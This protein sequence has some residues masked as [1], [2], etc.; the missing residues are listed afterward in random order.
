M[1]S[2][3][4]IKRL[5]NNAKIKINPEVKTVALTALTKELE[6][7]KIK[8]LAKT[9][10]NIWRLIMNSKITKLAAAAVI[11]LIAVFGVTV[12]DKSVTPAYAIEQTIEAMK[13]VVTV[14]FFAR[15]W[16]NRELETWIKVNPETGGND[17][18][19]VNEHER[20][21]ISIS[22][23]EITYFYHPMENKVRIVEGMSIRSDIR[24]GRFIEDVLD[25]LIEPKQGEIQIYKEHDPNT[26]KDIIILWAK[27][28]Q[29]ELEAFI[30]PETKL[31]IR[32]NFTKA[33]PGQIIKNVDEIYYNE[34]LPEGLFE[35]EIPEGTQ[36]IRKQM[37]LYI[38]E[39]PNYGILAEGLSRDEARVKILKEF[40]QAVINKDFKGAHM[41]LP[42]AGVERLQE[43]FAGVVELISIGEP[44]E[45]PHIDFGIL[46]PVRV[47]FS[48]GKILELYQITHFRTIDGKLSCVLAGEG[49]PVKW[50]E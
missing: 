46:T 44:F 45:V 30:D 47:M 19:Y 13:S 22:T 23:P 50:V 18:H 7:S 10:P 34:P 36:V 21:Q 35:F 20:G 31:P 29:D 42:V 4:K 48:N 32:I 1:R 37:L 3:E 16:Q 33:N 2:A 12:L 39:D 11:I 6:K 14:H 43:I 17:C 40:W 41:L 49:K 24:F 38:I 15:D 26:G 27:S 28:S 9:Q 25:K 5:I 8:N